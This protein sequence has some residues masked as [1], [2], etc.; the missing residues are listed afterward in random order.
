M[1]K[2]WLD[3]Q[4]TRIL[5]HIYK[6]FTSDINVSLTFTVQRLFQQCLLVLGAQ[7]EGRSFMYAQVCLTFLSLQYWAK[8]KDIDLWRL[9]R[10]D[11]WK[12]CLLPNKAFSTLYPQGSES[13]TEFQKRWVLNAN[14]SKKYCKFCLKKHLLILL[15]GNEVFSKQD[16]SMHSPRKLHQL[17]VLMTLTSTIAEIL[18]HLSH[19]IDIFIPQSVSR[20]TNNLAEIWKWDSLCSTNADILW[21]A[22]LLSSVYPWF[23][24]GV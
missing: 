13:L 3:I 14:C 15:W 23:E 21:T 11:P 2:Y 20:S 7:D 1:Q 19:W 9:Q 24:C 4:K 6:H 12:Y 18:M 5:L 10:L 17:S 22:E 8:E 16:I